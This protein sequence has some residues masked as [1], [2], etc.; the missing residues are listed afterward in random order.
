MDK[1]P[2][3][4]AGMFDGVAKRYD[5]TNTI[6]S[7]GNDLLWRVATV[8]AVAPVAGERIL[9]IAAGTGVSSAALAK[10]GARVVAVDISPGMLEVG[11]KRHKKIEF[12]EADALAL[13]FGDDEFDAVTISF[14]L[15][16][17]VD[18]KAALAEMYRV[19]KPG[20]RLVICE[21]SRPPVAI[22]RAGYH[23]YLKYV[24]P[25]VAGRASSNPEAYDYLGE[26]IRAW[27]EQGELSQWI[28]GAGFIRVAYRNLTG[29]VVA[30]HRGRKPIDATVLASV[31]RRK[32]ATRPIPTQ[33]R[34]ADATKQ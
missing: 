22:L 20:G 8:R 1:R 29:G 13:P 21:F 2:D 9:D 26:S 28:R 17:I 33:R 7:G 27:P 4:V 3:D 30:L 11:R 18:P 25:L 10:S 19:L 12:I 32:T 16:N 15:R 34:S 14:G 5:R 24:L 6:L 23:T 31:A